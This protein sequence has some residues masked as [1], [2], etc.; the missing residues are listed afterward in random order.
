MCY[1]QTLSST[2]CKELGYSSN[3]LL[4]SSCVELKEFK[5][6]EL[7]KTCK[8]CCLLDRESESEKKVHTP[9]FHESM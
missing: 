3:S 7:E 1:A 2:E 9:F 8:Q 5:L 6:T 4:C